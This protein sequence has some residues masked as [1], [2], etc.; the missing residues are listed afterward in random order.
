MDTLKE[1]L[2]EINKRAMVPCIGDL[3]RRGIV[4]N[5]FSDDEDI[6]GRQEV[7]RYIASWF[8][9]V[10][11]SEETCLQWM[12]E[13]SLDVLS[14]ISDSSKSQ[15]RHSTKSNIRY[16]YRDN[17]SFN[18]GCK[19]N[20]FKASCRESC[21]LYEEMLHNYEDRMTRDTDRVYDAEIEDGREYDESK[22]EKPRIKD[23]YSE[24]F[25]KAWEVVQKLIKEG[26]P[27]KK[28]VNILNESGLRTRTGRKWTYAIL[29]VELKNL[30]YQIETGKRTKPQA[31]SIKEIYKEQFEKGWKFALDL[32]RMDTPRHEVVRSLNDHGFKTRTGKPWT[33][34][35]LRAELKLHKDKG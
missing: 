18:C 17:I 25:E 24:Q 22:I 20:L 35:I 10:G 5:R 23:Q 4:F 31:I 13:Y 7:T 16:I 9:Y 14:A 12:T 28:I 27:R 6:P 30:P 11:I 33:T 34:P 26:L 19:D 32:I 29:G 8:R 1:I 2:R 15:I 21:P 3:V